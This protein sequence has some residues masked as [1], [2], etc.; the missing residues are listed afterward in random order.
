VEEKNKNKTITTFKKGCAK[1][2]L[3][4]KVEEKI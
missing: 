1:K 3:L 2:P 4:K